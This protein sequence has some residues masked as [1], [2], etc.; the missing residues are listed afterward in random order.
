MANNRMFLI[1]IPSQLGIMLGKRMGRGWY[2]APKK[3]ELEAFFNYLETTEDRQDDFTLAMEDCSESS[4][5]DNWR[6]TDTKVEG[7]AKFDFVIGK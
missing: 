3:E 4:C 7:F 6:Y 2:D 1:H 5:F